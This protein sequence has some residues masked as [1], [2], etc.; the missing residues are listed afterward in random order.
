MKWNDR[1]HPAQCAARALRQLR[2]LSRF[3]LDSEFRRIV[4]HSDVAARKPAS[5]VNLAS[6]F[7][8][9]NSGHSERDAGMRLRRDLDRFAL[10]VSRILTSK[11]NFNLRGAALP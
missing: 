6:P 4:G 7:T 10:E 2:D 11:Q 5:R 9:P 8:V 1:Y 3:G